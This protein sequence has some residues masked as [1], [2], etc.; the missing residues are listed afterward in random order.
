[1]GSYKG[2]VQ[3]GKID[4]KYQDFRDVP[5]SAD[6]QFTLWRDALQIQALKLTSQQSSLEA[7][8]KLTNFSQPVAQLTYNSNFDAAQM[9]AIARAPEVRGG[10]LGAER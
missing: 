7:S 9:G 2:S 3:V 6:L 1:M 4:L 8:G 5:A 10:T